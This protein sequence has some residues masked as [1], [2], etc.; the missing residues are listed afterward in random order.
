MQQLNRYKSMR[1]A[2][3]FLTRCFAKGESI[4]FLL[5]RENPA[6]VTQRVVLLE[7][8][9]ALR[10]LGWLAH[11]NSSGANIYVAAN[12]L[13]TGSRKRTKE[14]IAAVRHLYIDID[15]D[16]ENRLAALRASN[17]VP[18]PSAILSTS[19]N[20]YQVLWRVEG[21]EFESQESTLKLLALAFGGD[22][23]CTDCNRVLRVPGFLNL[24]YDPAHL[25]AVEYPG[26]KN[27]NPGDF[28]LDVSAAEVKVYDRPIPRGVHTR[29]QS[30]SELDWAWVLHEL[31]CGKESAK[32]TQELASRRSD[33]PTP[34]YYARRTVDVA[35]AL[36]WLT[37]GICL[38]DVVTM[39]KI[40]RRFEIPS[41]LCSARAHEIALTAQRMIARR[42]SA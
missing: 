16:G 20:K 11:E 19:P 12:P 17:A 35:S 22:A 37:E 30:N 3:D 27:W 40:R 42:K 26:N 13:R 32:L 31:A 39:L 7:R 25:V 4:A 2:Q 18:A 1:V 14:S 6:S 29:K 8:A 10:Y 33:K 9:V 15:N 41:S 21:L 24:K 5:R 38:D 23:A 34:L 36:L 28:K